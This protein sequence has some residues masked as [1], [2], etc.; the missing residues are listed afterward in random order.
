MNVRWSGEWDDHVFYNDYV[1]PEF[2]EGR[3][4]GYRITR[5]YPMTT[6]SA[7]YGSYASLI[8]R[9]RYFQDQF[10]VLVSYPWRRTKRE[11]SYMYS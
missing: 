3:G 7:D 2:D 5:V 9:R 6:L 4:E 8:L 1:F 11:K 10:T